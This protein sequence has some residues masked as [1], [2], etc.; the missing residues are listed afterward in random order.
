MSKTPQEK[1]DLFKSECNRW[2]KRFGLTGWQI[3]YELSDELDEEVGAACTCI[4]QARTAT[5]HLSANLDDEDLGDDEM[6]YF[7]LHE[8][9]E[10]I[11]YRLN[12]LMLAQHANEAEVNEARHEVINILLNFIRGMEEAE[13]ENS[14]WHYTIPRS[15]ETA[16]SIDAPRRGSRTARVPVGGG[17]NGV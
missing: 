6:C 15:A 7:A 13:H 12:E 11:L 3:W 8:V 10:I 16:G 1:F 17:K 14:L 4:V 9:L 5:L 2:I